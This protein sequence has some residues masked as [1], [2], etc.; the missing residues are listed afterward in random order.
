MRRGLTARDGSRQRIAGAFITALFVA[1]PMAALVGSTP[2]GASPVSWAT[3]FTTQGCT[4]WT[5]PGVEG[6]VSV[7]AIG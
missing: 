6:E 3:E 7:E 2:A 5:M 4:Q 1:A